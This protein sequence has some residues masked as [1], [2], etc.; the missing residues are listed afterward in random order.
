MNSIVITGC[1][2]GLG[3]GLV[4]ALTK[5]ENPPKH[6]ITTCRSIEKAKELT[7]IADEHK[8]VH[9]LQFDLHNLTTYD[10]FAKK[11]GDIV[12][13]DGL[14]VL[15][16]NAGVSPKY[17]RI[18]L[19]KAEHMSDT[20]LT[21]TIAPVMLTKALLPHLKL[22]AQKN[23]NKS[24]GVEKCAIINMSS[25]L[26]SVDNNQ[27]GGLYP[28][29]CSK[30]ALN[31][32]T[33]SM[34]VDLKNFGILATCIHPGWVKT[35]MGGKNAPLDVETSTEKI[36]NLLFQ[37]KETHNGNFYQFDGVQVPW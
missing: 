23:A 3:L 24:M 1:N 34:S 26:G 10:A 17:A 32:A 12:K 14:N 37:L 6:L 28:Y 5:L 27:D 29:R 21:N 13:D 31:M 20:Y 7:C 22:A 16:N 15:F 36:V 35:D 9:V 30:A 11:V 19:V 33:K 8:N 2:R 18:G 25:V 4:R